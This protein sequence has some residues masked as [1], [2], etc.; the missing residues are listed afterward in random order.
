MKR[1]IGIAEGDWPTDPE[2]LAGLVARMEQ[3]EPFDM[4]PKEEADR[5]AWRQKV[6]E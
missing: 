5:A 1:T 3:A 6:K 4:T 2:G